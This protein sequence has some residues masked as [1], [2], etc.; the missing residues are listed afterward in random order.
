MH[1]SIFIVNWK[2]YANLLE[3]SEPLCPKS[4]VHIP[5]ERSHCPF[6]VHGVSPPGQGMSKDTGKLIEELTYL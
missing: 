4:H 2:H 5:V 1:L 6:P 3:Q